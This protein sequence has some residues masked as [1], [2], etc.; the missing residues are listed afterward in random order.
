M[1]LSRTTQ[2]LLFAFSYILYYSPDFGVSDEMLRT[3][4]D[5]GLLNFLVMIPS[6]ATFLVVLPFIILTV[7]TLVYLLR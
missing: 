5:Y 6:E 4:W 3:Y 1:L 7:C 2:N